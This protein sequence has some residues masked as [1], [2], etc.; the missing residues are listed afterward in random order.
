MSPFRP[1]LRAERCDGFGDAPDTDDKILNLRFASTDVSLRV[2]PWNELFHIPEGDAHFAAL[3]GQVS[4]VYATPGNR[5]WGDQA[6]LPFLSEQLQVGF[7][8]FTRD[9]Q[10]PATGRRWLAGYNAARHDYPN[11]LALY[12]SGNIHYQILSLRTPDGP[13]GRPYSCFWRTEDLPQ[14]LRDHYHLCTG[15]HI[16]DGFTGGMN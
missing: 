3:Q 10:D 13:D 1:L 8:V 14:A 12:N 6:D 9:A 11:W 5:H 16:G 4:D 2:E 7:F 15:S